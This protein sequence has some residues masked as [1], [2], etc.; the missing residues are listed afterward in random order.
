M[1]FTD[2]DDKEE[3]EEEEEELV[4]IVIFIFKSI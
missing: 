3:E 2:V 1:K 4:G